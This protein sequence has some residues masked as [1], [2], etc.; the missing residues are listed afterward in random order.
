MQAPVQDTRD[1]DITRKP[2]S[3][4]EEKESDGKVRREAE[5]DRSLP[6]DRQEGSQD[7]GADEKDRKVVWKK[8]VHERNPRPAVGTLSGDGIT[9]HMA[10]RGRRI[11]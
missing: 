11:H 1:H 6:M 4:Q 3:V 2:D 10:W 9:L 7:Y 8:A 5:P